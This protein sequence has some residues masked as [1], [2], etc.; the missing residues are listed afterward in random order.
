MSRVK[1]LHCADLHLD[2]PFTSLGADSGKSAERRQDLKDT[3]R[4]IIE[5]AKSEKVDLLLI[6]G[7]LYE[8][9]YVLKS[10]INFINKCFESIPATKVF[11]VPGN[12]DPITVSSYYRNYSWSNNV[13][14]LCDE[15]P[16]V[17]LDDIDTYI[18][19]VGFKS[20]SQEKTI[21]YS[22]KPVRNDCINLMLV[23]GTVDMNIG[24]SLYNPMSSE[25][26]STL[27]MDY[28]A[29]GHFHGMLS[30]IGGKGIIYN[31]GSPEPLGFDEGGSHGVFIG[32]LASTDSAEKNLEL[33]F[34]KLN[35][36]YYETTDIKVD[37]CGS[38]EE[39][40]SRMDAELKCSD[41]PN[42]LLSV[43]LKGYLEESIKIDLLQ[44][45]NHFRDKL[46]YLKIK[47]E[48]LVNYNID[49]IVKEPG[50]KGLFVR[51]IMSRIEKTE[52]LCEKELLNKAL[53]YGLEALENGKLDL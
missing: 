17:Y 47:N 21:A 45:Q 15:L 6:S 41:A 10:T 5:L 22:L 33:R 24:N 35:K 31:P 18:Y 3:F 19:G 23:H 14:I 25:N 9:G 43:S 29:L 12:H 32:D 13:Y 49:Q 44:I 20:F 16:Y 46:Y 51:K 52:D 40:I 37:G 42:C 39:I 7:D 27:N 34:Q 30:D 11:I 26:L 4:N 8:H 36:R 53:Y 2:A 28:I 48:T 1:F 38:T 50:L